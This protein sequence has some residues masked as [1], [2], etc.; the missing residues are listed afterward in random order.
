MT[1]EEIFN[2]NIVS[3]T[4]LPTPREISAELPLASA[5]EETVL[6]HRREIQNIL[7]GTDPRLFLI[8]G[9]CSIHDVDAAIDYAKRLRN[10]AREVEDTFLLVMRVYFSKPRTSVGWKGLKRPEL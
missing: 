6:G 5:V 9:P 8:V 2:V 4:A 7:D 3:E 10:L 1:K